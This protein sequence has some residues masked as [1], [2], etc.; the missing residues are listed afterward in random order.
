M[1]GKHVKTEA[2]LAEAFGL[3]E[4]FYPM[5]WSVNSTRQSPMIT[6]KDNVMGMEEATAHILRYLNRVAANAND[7]SSVRDVVLTIPW[8]TN[9]RERQALIDA[10]EIAGYRVKMLAH[11]TSAA[12]LQRSMDFD[13]V[14]P[15]KQI[16][17]NM[18]ARKTEVCVAE[19]HQVRRFEIC[20]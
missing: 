15:E 20:S 9:N 13:P 16:I 18:G 19:F 10:A 5:Q 17:F 6:L 12:A 2:E 14:E 7:G 8:A 1:L 11:E 3:S 4:S